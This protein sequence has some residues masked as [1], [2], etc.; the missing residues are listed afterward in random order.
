MSVYV[1]TVASPLHIRKQT[2]ANRQLRAMS[3][4]IGRNMGCTAL[5]NSP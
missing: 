5:S 1:A 4:R 2:L 3:R